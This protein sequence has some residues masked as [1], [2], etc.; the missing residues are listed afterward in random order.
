MH[1]QLIL[2]DDRTEE[3]KYEDSNPHLEAAAE[4]REMMGFIFPDFEEGVYFSYSNWDDDGYEI[5]IE[6]TRLI[7]TIKA[8]SNYHLDACD[9]YRQ[10]LVEE[11]SRLWDEKVSQGLVPVA[12]WWDDTG[13]HGSYLPECPEQVYGQVKLLWTRPSDPLVAEVQAQEYFGD[14]DYDPSDEGLWPSTDDVF[15]DTVVAR[16]QARI[17]ELEKELALLKR[18]EHTKDSMFIK[19]EWAII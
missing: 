14:T 8:D 11:E 16:L 10:E 4:F 6:D 7:E 2:V 15:G 5:W 17:E 18:R 9:D 19:P 13:E 12:L 1:A 3:E